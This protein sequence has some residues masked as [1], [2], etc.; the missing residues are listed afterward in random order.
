MP[1]VISRF[2][3]ITVLVNRICVDTCQKVMLFPITNRAPLVLI[4]LDDDLFLQPSKEREN[5][6]LVTCLPVTEGLQLK[7]HSSN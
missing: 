1:F 2:H 4:Y 5:V 3:C 6:F 7:M